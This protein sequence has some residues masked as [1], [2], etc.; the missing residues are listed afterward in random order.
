ML[1]TLNFVNHNHSEVKEFKRNLES[2][3]GKITYL[4]YDKDADASQLDKQTN[5][6][7]QLLED[8]QKITSKLRYNPQGLR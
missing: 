2:I 3:L 7:R 4:K 6:A 8:Y 1:S 5:N